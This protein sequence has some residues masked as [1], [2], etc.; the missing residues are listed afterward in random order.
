MAGAADK[1]QLAW[2]KYGVDVDPEALAWYRACLGPFM[3][4]FPGMTVADYWQLDVDEHADLA[5]F[6]MHA[7]LMP[8]PEGWGGDAEQS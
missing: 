7:G 6:L 4:H 5:A 1:I 3:H 2:F 8:T